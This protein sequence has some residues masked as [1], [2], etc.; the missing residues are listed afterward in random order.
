MI[1]VGLG[2]VERKGAARALWTRDSRLTSVECQNSLASGHG[3]RHLRW[4][5]FLI[6]A[7][8]AQHNIHPIDLHRPDMG[9]PRQRRSLARHMLTACHAF[10]GE[11]WCVCRKLF[12]N[13]PRA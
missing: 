5:V 3:A 9:L 7:P 12:T 4:D 2:R 8:S 1:I 13:W 10:V 6:P 11:K